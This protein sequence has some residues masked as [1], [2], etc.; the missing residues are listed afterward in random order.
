[1]KR[2]HPRSCCGARPGYSPARPVSED[3]QQHRHA[4]VG[5]PATAA[6]RLRTGLPGSSAGSARLPP[7]GA[8][9]PPRPYSSARHVP[10]P[11]PATRPTAQRSDLAG[12]AGYGYCASHWRFF[13]GPRLHL[14]CT[15]TGMPILWALERTR[16]SASGRSSPRCLRSRPVWWPNTR[17]SR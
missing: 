4:S 8:L 10:V 6:N 16:R 7:G 17:A 3:R 9:G 14:V 15:P 5:G 2:G 11:A 1:M 12:W 13:W